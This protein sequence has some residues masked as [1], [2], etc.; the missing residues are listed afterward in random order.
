MNSNS[1][2]P[3]RYLTAP[4]LYQLNDEVTGGEAMV[5]DVHLLNSAAARPAIMVFGQAQFPT[6]VDKAA[7]LLHSLAYHHLFVDGNKRTA[8]RAVN[9]FLKLNGCTLNWSPTVAGNFILEIAQGKHDP[10]QIAAQLTRY[11]TTDEK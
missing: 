10:E 1:A 8:H 7:A 6:L 3:V 2:K 9:Q 4:E 11:I 5:R